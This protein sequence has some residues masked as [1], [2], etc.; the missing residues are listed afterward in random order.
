MNEQSCCFV[1]LTLLIFCRPRCCRRPRCLSSPI[2]RAFQEPM[3]LPQARDYCYFYWNTA[4]ER[5]LCLLVGH[6]DGDGPSHEDLVRLITL[7]QRWKG[8]PW[9]E[10][11]YRWEKNDNS[12]S[13]RESRFKT[14]L[15][16]G[17]Q[18]AD[19]KKFFEISFWLGFMPYF[20]WLYLVFLLTVVC[21]FFFQARIYVLSTSLIA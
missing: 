15:L 8:G 6:G 2:K 13:H 16:W 21:N 14:T 11:S 9:Q 3:S 17:G 10:N 1:N 20:K 12:D 18:W 7:L 5:V 4:E 19:L